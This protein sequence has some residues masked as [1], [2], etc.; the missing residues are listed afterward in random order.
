MKLITDT[1]FYDTVEYKKANNKDKYG[2]I[3]YSEPETKLVRYVKGSDIIK[4]NGENTAVEYGRVYHCPFEAGKGDI[5]DNHLVI[6]SRPA[7]DI[8]GTVHYWVVKTV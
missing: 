1:L 6:D 2:N 3:V 8:K 7:R 5:I 4:Y